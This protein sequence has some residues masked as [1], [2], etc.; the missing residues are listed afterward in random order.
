MVATSTGPPRPLMI[1]RRDFP[2]QLTW[3]YSF[4]VSLLLG[5]HLLRTTPSATAR[6]HHPHRSL[7]GSL[8]PAPGPRFWLCLPCSAKRSGAGPLLVASR[9]HFS[10]LLG[11]SKE[12]SFII[13]AVI[14]TA[15]TMEGRHVVS[16]VDRRFS[17]IAHSGWSHRR[18]CP[19]SWRNRADSARLS[20][21]HCYRRNPLRLWSIPSFTSMPH[22]S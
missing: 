8:R 13:S 10:V 17:V 4:G 5:R 6:V 9:V 12:L 7:R 11:I 15:Y 18:T 20:L 16:R 22:S 19:S 2:A 3:H 1:Q 14:V 21:G